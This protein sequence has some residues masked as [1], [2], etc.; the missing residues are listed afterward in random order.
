MEFD[1]YQ[2]EANGL[3]FKH[4]V[5]AN[6]PCNAYS[7]HTHN[8]YELLYFV[9]GDATL[10]IEDRR[11][12]LK[13]GDLVLIPPRKYHFVQIDSLSDYERYDILFDKRILNIES[14]SDFA[15]NMDI[16]NL[17]D[18][19]LGMNILQKT[20]YYYQNLEPADFVKIMTHLLSELFYV[21][22]LS[23]HK[24]K[25]QRFTVT[26]PLLSKALSYIN[27]NLVTLFDVEEVAKKCFVSKSYL[28]R[29]FKKE[30]LQTPKQYITGKRLLLAQ[31]KITD[32]EK[33]T[34]VYSCCGFSDYATF[35][36]NY[37]AFFGYQPSKTAANIKIPRTN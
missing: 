33:P 2:L 18:V 14:M 11:Y 13:S 36:R 19:P 21:I 34:Q 23:P 32:G 17:T 9:R 22:R 24:H 1:Q 31:S 7:K 20:D 5:S 29:L 30:L 26:N 12:K 25:T 10:V 28:F 35:Y 6:L 37:I 4:V 16:I 8:M 27:E 15:E 3:F